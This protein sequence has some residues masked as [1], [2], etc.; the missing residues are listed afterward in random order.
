MTL[1]L[2]LSFCSLFGAAFSCDAY[3]KTNQWPGRSVI[4]QMFEW[5]WLDIA[6]ECERFLGPK[7]YGAIQTSPASEN[8]VINLNGIRPWYERYQVMS[9]KLETRSGNEADFLNMTTRCNKVGVRVYVDVVFN[10]MTGG[11]TPETDSL[12]YPGVPYT[13]ENFHH[14]V[15][16]VNDYNNATEMRMCR[17]VG[18]QDLNQTM[19]YVR[20]K[21][22]GFLNKLIDLGVAGIRV[23]A[24]KHMWPADLKEIYKYLN[25]LNTKFG[26]RKNSRPYIYQEVAKGGVITY[27]EYKDMGDVTEFTVGDELAQ[28]FTGR[29]PLKTLKSWGTTA[30]DMM[31]SENAVAFVDNHDTQR[32]GFILTHR[33]ATLYKAAV[34]FLLAHPYGQPRIT[35]SYYFT[36]FEE[37]P[38]A[39]SEGNII[40]PTINEDQLC[41]GG[42]V[43][44]H[45]WG[46]VYRM[47]AFRNEVMNTEVNYWWDNGN[48]QV[49]FS[50]GDK[51]FIAFNTEGSEMNVEIQTELPSGT[52]CD[53][54][55]GQKEGTTCTGRNITVSTIGKAQITLSGAEEELYLA[56]HVG[57]E[58][59]L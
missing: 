51:G 29:K 37:G 46:P 3:I 34:A 7:G 28:I 19:P 36:S 57:K 47:V 54:I 56:I 49:A 24:A 11:G 1:L 39:D 5:K 18:L 16:D 40:S 35:S 42:W 27:E 31:P 33:N 2:W 20:Q 52:Y 41:D 44:E 30:L 12:S 50:L 13:E 23:D 21:I 38:P 15:C 59:A 17:L 6:E 14:P 9:Y 8:M 4:V 32:S 26:F 48:N 22:I 55:S 45:R 10:H 43:C 25:N 53:I 58:S